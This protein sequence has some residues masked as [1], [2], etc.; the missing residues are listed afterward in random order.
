MISC[1]H[2]KL[3]VKQQKI[4]QTEYIDLSQS[5][6]REQD[7][8]GATT[9]C[10]RVDANWGIKRQNYDTKARRGETNT[11]KNKEGNLMLTY[12]CIFFILI[13]TR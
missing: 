11:P 1:F 7:D 5:F 9:G 4:T 12:F 6:H 13:K 3:T 10:W 8:N 2:Y